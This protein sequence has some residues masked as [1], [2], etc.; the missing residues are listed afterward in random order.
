MEMYEMPGGIGRIMLT[1]TPEENE[2]HKKLVEGRHKFSQEYIKKKGW[3]QPDTLSI[4]QIME[5]REQEGW[6]NPT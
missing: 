4:P 2:K 6:K 5:I 1:G 3:G